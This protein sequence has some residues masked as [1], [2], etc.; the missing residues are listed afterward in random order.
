MKIKTKVMD[1]DQVAALPHAAHKK[2]K[3]PGMLARWLMH[4]LSKGELKKVRFHHEEIGMEALGAEEPALF[5]M[6]HSSFI[7]LKIASGLLYPRPYGIVCTSDGFVGKEGLM[8]W[9]GCFPTQKFVPDPTLVK[10]MVH[11]TRKENC[12]VLMYPEASYSF[13]GT[14]TPLPESLGKLV[15]L[16]KVPVVMIRTEGAFARDPLYNNLQLRDVQVGAVMKYLY[17]PDQ[18]KELSVEEINECLKEEFSFDYFRWQQDEQIRIAEDFRADDLQ[19]AL[20]RCPHCQSESHMK[21]KGIRIGCGNCGASYELT[22]Y[23][24]LAYELG[25]CQMDDQAHFN[26]V[27]DWYRW[28]RECV[29]EEIEKGIYGLDLEVDIR[30]L[31]NL[32]CIYEV[33]QGRL[34]HTADGFTLDGCEDRLHYE[35]SPLAS[36]SL[37]SDFYWYEL[38]DMICIGD[39]KTLYYCFPRNGENVVAK[40]RI[41]AECLFSMHQRRK[42]DTKVLSQA[43]QM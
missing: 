1:Y 6:N 24:A 23:G 36:Y 39:N 17:G 40:A 16:L 28:Q 31:V 14:A 41:A 18:I 25:S 9:I 5:L 8:R 10:D 22:E 26:H 7:D 35:Q 2:P 38:G 12:S 30:M 32:D 37:Y 3:A 42:K 33:G 20:Y 34:R 27:P 15:K 13:D 19:R 29:K 4:T 11:L 21:G 43:E